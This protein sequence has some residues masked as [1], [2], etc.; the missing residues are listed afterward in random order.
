MVEIVRVQKPLA[1][2]PLLGELAMHFNLSAS[3]IGE[4]AGVS[5]QSVMRWYLGY[6]S[7][8]AGMHRRLAPFLAFLLWAYAA[9]IPPF[10]GSARDRKAAFARLMR[11]YLASE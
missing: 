3:M 2:G 8:S 6:G 7:P 5:A 9:A 4:L 10:Q 11:D 1:T